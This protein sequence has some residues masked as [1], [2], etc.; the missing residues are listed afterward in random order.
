MKMNR[1]IIF[2]CKNNNMCN[3]SFKKKNFSFICIECFCPITSYLKYFC[4]DPITEY[5]AAYTGVF[6]VHEAQFS[7]RFESHMSMV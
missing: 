3:F 7:D 1:I 4:Q 2:E 5:R 6:F